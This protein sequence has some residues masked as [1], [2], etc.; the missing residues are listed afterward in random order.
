MRFV[1]FIARYVV[2]AA[3]LA[4]AASCRQDH[5]T[6]LVRIDERDSIT[7]TDFR[8]Y[9]ESNSSTALSAMPY[10][11]KKKLLLGLIDSRLKVLSA[12][13][14]KIHEDEGVAALLAQA[15]RDALLDA[16]RDRFVVSHF[17]NDS[18][19]ATFLRFHGREITVQNIVIRYSDV[20][21]PRITRTYSEAA[22]LADSIYRVANDSNFAQLAE[23]LSDYRDPK[24]GKGFSRPERFRY[25]TTPSDYENRVFAA[26]PKTIVRPIDLAGAF[27]VSR[28]MQF[29]VDS[30]A[31]GK[32]MTADD[33]RRTLRSK[34]DGIDR[35]SGY[36]YFVAFTD[37]LMKAMG[38][39]FETRSIDSLAAWFPAGKTVREAARKFDQDRQG[40]WIARGTGRSLTVA[41]FLNRSNPNLTIPAQSPDQFAE[42]VRSFVRD[43][44]LVTTASAEGL[45]RTDVFRFRLFQKKHDILG[46]RI[47]SMKIAAVGDTVPAATLRRYYE[48]HMDDYRIPG[49][50]TVKEIQSS[51][52]E[53]AEAARQ[54]VES[55]VAFERAADSVKVL[56]KGADIRLVEAVTYNSNQK[57][58][59]TREAFRLDVNDVSGVVVKKDNKFTL[60]KVT[61]KKEQGRQPFESAKAGVLNQYRSQVRRQLEQRWLS[62]LKRN[63]PIIVF[64]NRLP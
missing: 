60:I 6:L 64:E 16:A 17:V 33:I 10:G 12:Y 45:D 4:C 62:E 58:E 38:M 35:Q 46:R 26:Q 59:V 49:R 7:V 27:L 44:L 29:G 28:I 39:T 19:V 3:V 57:T 23:L 22:A 30:A 24:S 5:S 61:D 63:I 13:D 55:G 36:R 48:D 34:L 2:F 54:L 50:V 42:Y 52:K 37:S 43:E 18:T 51:S 31:L 40:L 53:M 11:D 21:N 14:E 47:E 9:A 15:E 41:D 56:H 20:P 1:K 32:S 8:L 25:G